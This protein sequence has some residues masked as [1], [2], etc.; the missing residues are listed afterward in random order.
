[1]A[2]RTACS[3]SELA[4]SPPKMVQ[5]DID[6]SYTIALTPH[7]SII[8][9]NNVIFHI[10]GGTDFTDLANSFLEVELDVTTAAGEALAAGKAVCPINNIFHSLWSQVQVKLKATLV[11]ITDTKPTSRTCSIFRNRAK[12]PG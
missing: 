1:M 3:V 6:H 12:I 9:G 10:E 4:Y 7:N 8:A 11:P 5:Q 2:S